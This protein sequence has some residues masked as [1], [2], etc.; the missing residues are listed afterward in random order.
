MLIHSYSLKEWIDKNRDLLKPPIGNRLIWPQEDYIVMAVGG[1][2]ERTDFHVNEGEEFFYQVE[3]DM[4][5]KVLEPGSRQIRDIS[6]R[7]GDI[8]LLRSRIPHSPQRPAG[9]V[10]L[11]IE[12]KRRAGQKDRLQWYCE[13]C[14]QLLYEEVF[15]LTDIVLQFQAVFKRYYDSEYPLCKCGHLNGRKWSHA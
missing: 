12:S 5:L 15:E 14:V 13:E 8:Y 7:Q 4:V 11:V 9:S 6:I 2:N 3:G 10:G 1:P